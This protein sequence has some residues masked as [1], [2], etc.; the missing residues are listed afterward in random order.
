MTQLFHIGLQ[1]PSTNNLTRA[2]NVNGRPLFFPTQAAKEFKKACVPM[3]Q[4]LGIKPISGQC[5][6][7]FH[8]VPKDRRGKTDLDNKFKAFCDCL[9]SAQLIDDD[10]RISSINAVKL[11]P[12][13][14][15]NGIFFNITQE[16]GLLDVPHNDNTN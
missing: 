8:W 10:S 16:T 3:L 4:A 15:E 2:A 9:V 14:L 11:P 12:N 1:P 13:K 5:H 7:E 6:L